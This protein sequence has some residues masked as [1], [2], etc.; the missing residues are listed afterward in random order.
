MI[1]VGMKD[2]QD[3]YE[4]IEPFVFKTP[5]IYSEPTSRRVGSEV[6]FK[7]ENLQMGG[8]H[9]IRGALNSM[10]KLSPEELKRGVVTASAGNHS[11]AV[12]YAAKLMETSAIVCV[13][14]YAPLTKRQKAEKYGAQLL[15]CGPHFEDAERKAFEVARE[16]G[17][18][19]I[20]AYE[21]PETIAG[22][23]TVM[24]ECFREWK[25]FDAVLVPTGGGGLLCGTAIACKAEHP[26]TKVY[27]L[28]TEASAPWL[29]S[30]HE[31]TLH[32][33]CA[34]ASTCADGL[35]GAIGW[36]NVELALTCVD[37]IFAVTEKS[38]RE[39][40]KW[41]S[42]M[43]NLMIEGAAATCLGALFERHEALQGKRVL[44]LISGGNIDPERFC[45]ICRESY[46]WQKEGKS[47]GEVA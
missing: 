36:P 46:P 39:G 44:C 21:T 15:V 6:W 8:A 1:E 5:M 33:D 25:D 9:K 30:F 40:I 14:E 41:T 47:K 10:L 4:Q 32:N 35:E 28:Q 43:H 29:R 2:I 20:H 7:M 17:R 22:Q 19:F 3:A 38:L 18:K 34:Y 26:E 31:K 16:T 37:D 42:V 27:G 12:A 24:L 11:L 13:P 23:G 45:E